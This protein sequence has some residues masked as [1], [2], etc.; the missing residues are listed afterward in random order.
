MYMIQC[1]ETRRRLGHDSIF[2]INFLLLFIFSKYPDH[3]FMRVFRGR[4]GKC[5]TEK[6]KKSWKS[7]YS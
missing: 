3:V 1:T 7:D 6:N 4:G 2:K 5:G